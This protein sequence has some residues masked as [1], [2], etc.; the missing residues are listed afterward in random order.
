MVD[1]LTAFYEANSLELPKAG[2]S[3]HYRIHIETWNPLE[4]ANAA[5]S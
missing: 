2:G 3:W 5:D 1:V 4:E